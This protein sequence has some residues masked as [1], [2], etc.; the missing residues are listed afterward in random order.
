MNAFLDCS[1]RRRR[2]PE[3]ASRQ[4]FCRYDTVTE[5]QFFDYGRV[6]PP[7]LSSKNTKNLGNKVVA[8]W[9]KKSPSDPVMTMLRCQDLVFLIFVQF[10]VAALLFGRRGCIIE[11][12]DRR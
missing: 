9:K 12:R 6:K 11:I 2:K 8:G 5:D 10:H 1:K 7:F 4:S 3:G